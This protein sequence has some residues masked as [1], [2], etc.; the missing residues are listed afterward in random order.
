M[1][2]SRQGREYMTF[3]KFV[4]S[5]GGLLAAAALATATPAIATPFFFSTGDPDGK[6]ATASRPGTPGQFEIESADDFNLPTATRLTSATFTGLIPAGASVSNVVL[7]IYRVFPK[8]SNTNRTPNVPT[9]MNSPSD[10]AFES[11]ALSSGKLSITTTSLAASFP[12]ANSVQPG[13]ILFNAT[14]TT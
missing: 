13:G 7:E 12:A 9:R 6:T 4:S 1:R 3:V 11:R 5:I 10:V 14:A 2:R 8:D